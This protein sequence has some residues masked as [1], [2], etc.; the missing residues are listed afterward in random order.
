MTDNW[1]DDLPSYDSTPGWVEQGEIAALVGVRLKEARERVGIA[2]HDAA[3]LLG[4]SNSSKLSKIESGKHSSQV[5][6]WV[7][8][9][10]AELYCVSLDW[11]VGDRKEPDLTD[12]HTRDLML[13]YRRIWEGMRKRDLAVQDMVAAEVDEIGRSLDTVAAEAAE[14]QEAMQRFIEL[15]PKAW[16]ESRGGVRLKDAI[17]RAELTARRG[18]NQDRKRREPLTVKPED[19]GQVDLVFI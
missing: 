9:R 14:M 5:P 17:D 16:Q 11:L 2:Q 10:A 7:L 4:Y 13:M 18:R 19:A 8:K 1:L 3:E 15:N 6:L 12:P